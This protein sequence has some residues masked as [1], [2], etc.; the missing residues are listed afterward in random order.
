MARREDRYAESM[1]LSGRV[2]E[3]ADF[4][5]ELDQGKGMLIVERFSFKGPIRV[6][7]TR[8][9]LYKSCPYPLVDWLTMARD[10]AFDRVRD[11]CH[12]R[13]TG[14]TGEAMLLSGTKDQWRTIRGDEILSFREDVQFVEIPPPRKP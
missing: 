4:I 3:W 7:W 8:D 12:T 14:A 6:W 10:R 2:M 9:N 1:K 11:W 5:R 13:Y